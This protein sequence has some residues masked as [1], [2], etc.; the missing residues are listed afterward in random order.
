MHIHQVIPA[1]IV[2]SA[3]YC[4]VSTLPCWEVTV[5][6]H[7][8]RLQLGPNEPHGLCANVWLPRAEAPALGF[9]KHQQILLYLQD[10]DRTEA[11]LGALDALEP[12]T[13]AE[14]HSAEELAAVTAE[15][16][17]DVLLT[18]AT[19]PT[20]SGLRDVAVLVC[21]PALGQCRVEHAGDM[22]AAEAEQLIRHLGW[23]MQV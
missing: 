17:W 13:L 20:L 2:K 7:A 3:L 9:V 4:P 19:P 23:R 21:I 8:G 14:I 1:S 11:A 10:A 22:A 5:D 12:A 6:A 16:T 15:E 18:D